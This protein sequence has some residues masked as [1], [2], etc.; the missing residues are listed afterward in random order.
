MLH[1]DADESC[2]CDRQHKSNKHDIV[3]GPHIANNHCSCEKSQAEHHK[4][5]RR[6]DDGNDDT[7]GTS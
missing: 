2:E 7:C 6:R 3:F 5:D 1:F 4:S